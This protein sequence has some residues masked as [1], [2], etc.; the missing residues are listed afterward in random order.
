MS[1][2]LQIVHVSCYPRECRFRQTSRH[3]T[4]HLAAR[5]SAHH[6]AFSDRTKGCIAPVLHRPPAGPRLSTDRMRSAERQIHRCTQYAVQPTEFAQHIAA[7]YRA[8]RPKVT[9]IFE[10]NEAACVKITSRQ[11]AIVPL[12]THF[13]ILEQS[14]ILYSVSQRRVVTSLIIAL[15]VSGMLS[16][17][18][19]SIAARILASISAVSFR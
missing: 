4:L 10:G 9:V 11:E 7:T 5:G 2:L 14:L 15:L 1:A 13:T 12:L 6:T 19:S 16:S 8:I 3:E 18:I 17:R